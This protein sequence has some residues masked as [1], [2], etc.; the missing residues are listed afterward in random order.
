MNAVKIKSYKVSPRGK[1]GFALSLPPLWIDDLA[2]KAG[3]RLDLYRDTAGRLILCPP[4]VSP[5]LASDPTSGQAAELVA[6]MAGREA[7]S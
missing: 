3:D 7:Q 6:F 5:L 1:R 4:G 2:I